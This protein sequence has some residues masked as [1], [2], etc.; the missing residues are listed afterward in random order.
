ML[1]DM[2]ASTR[3]GILVSRLDGLKILIPPLPCHRRDGRRN[4][5][6]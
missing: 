5:A 4:A 2:I 1:D 6:D 3:R